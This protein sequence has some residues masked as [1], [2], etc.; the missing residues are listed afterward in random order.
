MTMT[1][2]KPADL[3]R[4][5]IEAIRDG[6]KG[7]GD[8]LPGDGFDA[9]DAPRLD[10]Y[11][12]GLGYFIADVTRSGP[13]QLQ[14]VTTACGMRIARNGSCVFLRDPYGPVQFRMA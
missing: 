6:G 9:P 11:L 5:H 7:N 8:F 10:V 4:N 13:G 2:D 12:V 1:Y 3:I 14:A